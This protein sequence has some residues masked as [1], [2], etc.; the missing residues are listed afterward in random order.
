MNFEVDYT[1]NKLDPAGFDRLQ[2]RSPRILV[3]LLTLLVGFSTVANAQTASKAKEL[4]AKNAE[5]QM[6]LARADQESALVATF[7]A[8]QLTAKLHGEKSLEAGDKW[9]EYAELALTA[10]KN[11]EA[12]NGF[13]K[14]F[15]IHLLFVKERIGELNGEA[16]KLLSL[17]QRQGPKESLDK[18][19]Q[20]I[21]AIAKGDFPRELRDGLFNSLQASY[22]LKDEADDIDG[23]YIAWA[24]KAIASKDTDGAD[25]VYDNYYCRHLDTTKFELM[26]EK[27]SN[28]GKEIERLRSTYK[29]PTT[30]VQANLLNANPGQTSITNLVRPVYPPAAK[31]VRARGVVLVRVLISKEGHVEKANAFCGHPLLRAASARAASQSTFT[32]TL[33]NGEPVEVSGVIVFN[34]Q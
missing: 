10:G 2:N 7:E 31:A 1:R 23:V 14:A 26:E 17:Y 22:S 18:F 32:P 4:E 25:M 20:D 16:F 24:E 6:F 34:F 30:L 29:F 12:I 15:G 33:L 13:E 11:A 19:R 9:A 8:V 21:L 5:I 3:M 28:F 27:V